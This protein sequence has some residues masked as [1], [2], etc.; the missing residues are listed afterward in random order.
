[1]ESI[2]MISFDQL[3][4]LGVADPPLQQLAQPILNRD[5]VCNIANVHNG[6]VLEMMICAGNY[7]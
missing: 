3:F 1:M 6:H 7:K 2:F 4:A 5:A